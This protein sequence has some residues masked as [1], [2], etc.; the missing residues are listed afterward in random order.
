MDY[1]SSYKGKSVMVAGGGGFLGSQ[2]V[3]LLKEVDCEVLV[4]RTKDGVD[5]T[6]REVCIDYLGEHSPDIVINCAAHQGGIKYQ[7][8]R[9]ATIYMDN[10]L[11][12]TF[13]MEAASK[14]WRCQVR[15]YCSGMFLPGVF[16]QGRAKRRRLL[17]W[18]AS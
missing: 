8:E 16:R 13:L 17:V 2:I 3:S 7:E 5:F 6:K 18:A 1:L 10:L 12:G 11:M 15:Q 14:S 9:R 4:P